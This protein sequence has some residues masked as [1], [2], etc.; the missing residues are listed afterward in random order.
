MKLIKKYKVY[1]FAFMLPILLYFIILF[2]KHIYPFGNLANI[3]YDENIQ[4]EQFFNFYY[5]V[6][7]GNASIDY[8][9]YK[10]L[11][12]SLVAL[13]GYYLASPVNL[14]LLFFN[15][16]NVLNFVFLITLIKIG[17]CGL[18]FSIF[19]KHRFKNLKDMHVIMLSIAYSFTQYVV[20]QMVNI[21][22][23]DGVFMLP[24]ILYFIEVYLE[25]NK[26]IGL[27]IT[28]ICTIVFNWYTGYMNCLFAFLYF[29][30]RL[31]CIEY[32]KNKHITIFNIIKKIIRFGIIE[33]LAVLGSA[34]I[35]LPVV[36]AQ[37]GSRV[38][39]QNNIFEF[40]TNGSFLNIF[41]GFMI[42][43]ENPSTL[44]T[45][46]C[47]IFCFILIIYYVF[48]KKINLFEKRAT[49]IFTFIMVF[50]L[51]F[52]PL[53]NMW[54]GFAKEASF[55]YR[56]LYL[57][58]LTLLMLSAHILSCDDNLDKKLI[59]KIILGS[60]FAFLIFDVIS[61][62]NPK[63]LFVQIIILL[64]YYFIIC[65][66]KQ[67]SKTKY[68]I[69]GLFLIEIIINAYLVVGNSYTVD[70][71]Y[72][73]NYTENEKNMINQIKS[74]DDGFYRIETNV[75]RDTK[76]NSFIS[77][78]SLAHSYSTIEQY[79]SSYDKITGQ[80]LA[81][82]GYSRNEF[83]TFYH[84]PI[85]PADSLLGVKYLLTDTEYDGF[86]LKENF[87]SYNN[88]KV[89]ENQHA[90]PMIINTDS[91]I[92]NVKSNGN[93]F[94]YINKIYSGILGRNV[95]L[96]T[97]CDVLNKRIDSQN[98]NYKTSIG[99][100]R[101]IIYFR[102]KTAPLET[103]FIRDDNSE[104]FYSVG[105]LNHNILVLGNDSVEHNL[106]VKDVNKSSYELQF[107]SLDLDLFNSVIDEIKH[108]SIKIE[109]ISNNH[110]KFTAE[111][112]NVLLTVP[113]DNAWKISANDENVKPLKG[114]AGLLVIPLFEGVNNIDMTYTVKG[115]NI[116]LICTI[117]SI[118][119][120][121]IYCLFDNRKYGNKTKRG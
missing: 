30:Y 96:F 91:D 98:Y 76:R 99:N 79:T 62:F 9:F 44:I 12:G 106:K 10:S 112:D 40:A 54:V 105:W 8:S 21:M 1:L 59:K 53:E 120:F 103:S 85:L 100:G 14:I 4:Y 81:N 87:K 113:Y 61:P 11:G 74:V 101:N 41:R 29:I 18:T 66:M 114:A 36:I 17:L 97:P 111:G 78:E 45:L 2:L 92:L 84:E 25:Q 102:F 58:I 117:S 56:F 65:V 47:S 15:S 31:I 116:G 13:W 34:I 33:L 43:S 23:L 104:E 75:D 57:C 51:F 28:F 73:L 64:L 71:D 26:K 38:G 86:T 88:K 6:L 49:L 20:G 80:F 83:P 119:L 68:L 89:Y 121:I 5:N 110:I 69:F 77:N 63:R 90:L 48:C 118:L 107:Y 46:F 42:G 115:K 52:K 37:L 24:L 16:M 93:P 60:I 3:A 7:H 109:D 27:Y 22:W 55:Q 72:Y 32:E 35:F 94:E 67:S 108:N 39:D 70:K 19:I 50:S 82:L 95:E